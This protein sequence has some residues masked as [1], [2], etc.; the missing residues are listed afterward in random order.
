MTEKYYT[1]TE[2]AELLK[3]S[4]RTVRNLCLNGEIEHNRIGSQIRISETQLNTY[5]NKTVNK[6]K[7]TEHESEY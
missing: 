1:T 5:L 6:E 2:I 3:I 4:D 7:E